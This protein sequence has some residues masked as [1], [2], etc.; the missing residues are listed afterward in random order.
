MSGLPSGCADLPAV[1]RPKEFARSDPRSRFVDRED[2]TMSDP[3]K[4]KIRSYRQSFLLA[5][6]AVYLPAIVPLLFGP[7]TAGGHGVWPY[8]QMLVVAPGVAVAAIMPYAG[9]AW[10]GIVTALLLLFMTLAARSLRGLELAVIYGPTM[11]LL[12]VQYYAFGLMLLS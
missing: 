9:F 5:V 10:M 6:I 3:N 11:A 12:G 2:C 1:W 8:L 4:P 7:L